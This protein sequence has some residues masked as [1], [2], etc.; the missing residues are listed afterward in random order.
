MATTN[1]PDADA[2][3]SMLGNELR[4]RREAAGLSQEELAQQVQF[5]RSQV[6]AVEAGRRTMA[7]EMATACDALFGTDGLFLRL[8]KDAVRRSAPWPSFRAWGDVEREA[9]RLRGFEAVW[10]PGLFQ[11]P[12]YAATVLEHNED[13]IA[14][15]LERQAILAAENPPTVRYL[16]DEWVLRRP[17]GGPEVMSEQLERLLQV[18]EDG[19]AAI[20]TVPSGA[21]PAYNGSFVLA[22]LD[23]E[24]LGYEEATTQ[25]VLLSRRHDVLALERAYDA[26]A[27]EALPMSASVETIRR[28]KEQW[29]T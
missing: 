11:T 15:R 21:V 16:I 12:A 23:E 13:A 1:E 19:Q 4:Y 24:T 2:Q 18:I 25:G 27:A 7:P 9:I 10:M 20:H 14:A 29:T 5:S 26:L 6:Q 28:M 8:R 3:P 17:I 22:T